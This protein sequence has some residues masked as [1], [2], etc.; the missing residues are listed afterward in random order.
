MKLSVKTSWRS[1]VACPHGFRHCR[2]LRRLPCPSPDRCPFTA[3]CPTSNSPIKTT[4]RPPWTPCAGQVC[5]ADVIFT[6]CAGQ[7][8]IM[9]AHMKELQ[10]ALPAGSPVKLVSFTTDPAFDTPAVLKKYAGR[11]DAQDGQWIFLTGDKAALRH[12]TVDGLKLDR[13]GQ[14]AWR[15]GKRRR[16]LHPQRQI[17]PDRQERAHP[18]ILRRRN[19]GSRRPGPRRR[20]IPGP[21]M[22]PV[23]TAHDP[24]RPARRQRHPQRVER[25]LSRP[26]ATSSSKRKT[27]RRTATA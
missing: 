14:N 25:D 27:C 26:P 8:L 9:S 20:P 24:A 1:G 15:T 18:G 23:P 17:R 22:K 19:S 5:I 6:R 13:P 10:A 11:Y 21:P 2:R 3:P 16:S 12:A 4:R 7:C